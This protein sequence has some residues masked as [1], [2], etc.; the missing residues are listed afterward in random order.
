M[1]NAD[2][3]KRVQRLGSPPPQAPRG[4]Q[5][6]R[7]N[8]N[9]PNGSKFLLIG[10]GAALLALGIQAVRFA[11]RNYEAIRDDSGPE[12]AAGLG[13]GGMAAVVIGVIVLMRA[14]L[15]RDGSRPKAII[16][17]GSLYTENS[18]PEATKRAK[19]FSS[20]FGFAIGV[21]ACITMFLA[22]AARFVEAE[23]AQSFSVDGTYVAFSSLLDHC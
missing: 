19:F 22:F 21:I 18:R 3:Q 7:R 4:S 17:D 20:V 15:K 10:V 16:S 9:G 11:N 1:S 23:A 13:L 5:S 12:L 14:T 6:N 8:K 2:F